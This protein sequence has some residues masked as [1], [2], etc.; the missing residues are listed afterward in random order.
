MN[1]ETVIEKD[2]RK[3]KELNNKGYMILSYFDFE[4]DDIEKIKIDIITT[5]NEKWSLNLVNL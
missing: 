5:L 2:E 1:L 4:L 3:M